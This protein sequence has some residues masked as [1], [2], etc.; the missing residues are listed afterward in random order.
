VTSPYT[1]V[2]VW[3]L[4]DLEPEKRVIRMFAGPPVVVSRLWPRFTLCPH[5]TPGAAPPDRRGTIFVVVP[6][7]I[8]VVFPIVIPPFAMVVIVSLAATGL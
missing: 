6:H 1:R 8:V 4:S 3:R 2:L 5:G 7:V